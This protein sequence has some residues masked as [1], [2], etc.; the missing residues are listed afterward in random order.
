M[1][2]YIK[3]AIGAVSASA[4]FISVSAFTESKT[5]AVDHGAYVVI[6]VYEIPAYEDKGLH[7]HYGNAKT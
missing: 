1:N 3:Y 7:I 4:L 6:D 5:S 2:K